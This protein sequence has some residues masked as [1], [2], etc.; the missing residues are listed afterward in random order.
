LVGDP[1]TF[2][3]CQGD[4]NENGET[5]DDF[6]EFAGHYGYTIG[7]EWVDARTVGGYYPLSDLNEDGVIEIMD[8]VV[9]SQNYGATNSC[10]CL[11][12]DAFF[13]LIHPKW[14]RKFGISLTEESNTNWWINWWGTQYNMHSTIKFD[15]STIHWETGLYGDEDFYWFKLSQGE[16]YL[17]PFLGQSCTH[18][19]SWR[20]YIKYR[21]NTININT[22]TWQHFHIAIEFRVRFPYEITVWSPYHGKYL[23]VWGMMIVMFFDWDGRG[24]EAF[25]GPDDI[26]RCSVN[27]TAGWMCINSKRFGQTDSEL[28]LGTWKT[29]HNVDIIEEVKY[30][31]DTDMIPN[32]T[33]FK[34]SQ[35]AQFVLSQ[36]ICRHGDL[37]YL[38]TIDY[39]YDYCYWRGV[40]V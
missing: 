15:Y 1:C 7:E 9:L 34:D 24:W 3:F 17:G 16:W 30:A 13:Q 22:I 27:D 31:I 5:E 10:H 6:F 32:E 35:I 29:I 39:S 4:V 38:S 8:M 28:V 2:R 23:P 25:F 26:K 19:K 37:D 12:R 20:S 40:H 36:S 18:Y 21:A 11:I 33:F 14:R